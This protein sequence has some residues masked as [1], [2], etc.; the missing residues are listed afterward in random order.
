MTVQAT[1]SITAAMGAMT[2]EMSFAAMAR[3]MPSPTNTPST[4]R[5][6]APAAFSQASGAV[7]QSMTRPCRRAFSATSR[8]S[9]SRS[10]SWSQAA[11]AARI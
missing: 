1:A 9:H 11:S 4:P 3:I 7:I 8:A 10:R 2:R 6:A 5:T